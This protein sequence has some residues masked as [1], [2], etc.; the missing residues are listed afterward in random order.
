MSKDIFCGPIVNDDHVSSIY[1]CSNDDDGGWKETWAPVLLVE[2]DR[3]VE[4]ECGRFSATTML[5]RNTFAATVLVELKLLVVQPV[6]AM[7]FALI[8]SFSLFTDDRE[9]R[10]MGLSLERRIGFEVPGLSRE[11]CVVLWLGSS[12]KDPGIWFRCVE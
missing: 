7:E 11:L 12:G 4:E 1:G 3:V 8:C 5:A 9:M 2:D 6:V 10:R